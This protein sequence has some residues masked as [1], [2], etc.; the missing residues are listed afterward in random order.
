[1]CLNVR[2]KT[3]SEDTKGQRVC[4]NFENHGN[5]RHYKLYVYQHVGKANVVHFNAA[6]VQIEG[7]KCFIWIQ[8]NGDERRF[9]HMNA[10]ECI[11][12]QIDA[13]DYR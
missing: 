4:K 6:L 2:M 13:L 11:W 1:M 9:R 8:M 7:S 12:M 10:D 5:W 3:A